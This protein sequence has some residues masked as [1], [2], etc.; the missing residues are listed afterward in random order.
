MQ[1]VQSAAR[2]GAETKFTV[3]RA[4]PIDDGQPQAGAL[5]LLRAIPGG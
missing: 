1:G 4:R 3:C 2:A 5:V